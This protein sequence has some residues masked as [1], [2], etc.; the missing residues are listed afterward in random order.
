MHLIIPVNLK[1]MIF[2]RLTFRL[3]DKSKYCLSFEPYL[4]YEILYT[5][6]NKRH[7]SVDLFP[8]IKSKWQT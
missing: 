7:I 4:I 2:K 5:Q 6:Y 1:Q 3:Y 8:S